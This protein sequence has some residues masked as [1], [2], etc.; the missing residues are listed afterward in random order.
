MTHHLHFALCAHHSTS[1]LSVVPYLPPFTLSSPHPLHSD[2]DRA[3]VCVY[4]LMLVC[5]V[6]FWCWPPRPHMSVASLREPGERE[7]NISFYLFATLKMLAIAPLPM[8][9]T[10]THISLSFQTTLPISPIT[11]SAAKFKKCPVTPGPQEVLRSKEKGCQSGGRQG[12]QPSE[13]ILLLQI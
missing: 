4:E 1:N 11:F 5:L 12:S 13:P 10:E 6:Y 7:V 2:N 9:A 3:V 8:G